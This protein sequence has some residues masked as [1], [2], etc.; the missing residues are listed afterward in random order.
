MRQETTES[1]AVVLVLHGP[2]IFDTGEAA[3]L[4]Q[5][6][7]PSRTIVTGVMARTAAEESGLPVEYDGSPP[8]RIMRALG[9]KSVLANHAKTPESGRIFGNIVASRLGSEG[10]IQIE[11]S[12]KTVIVWDAGDKK[13]ASDISEAT[14]YSLT[15]L[16]ST[17]ELHGNER[18]IRGCLPGEPVYVN[19]MIIGHATQDTVV[20]RRSGTAIEAVSGLVPKDHGIEKLSGIRPLDLATAWCK[21]GQ[22]R[23]VAP[24]YHR[25]QVTSGRVVVVDHCGHEIYGKIGPDCCGVLAIGD[26]TTA[27][28]GHICSHRGIPVLGIVDGDRDTIL[29]SAFADG[30]VVLEAQG[31]RDDDLGREVAR[32]AEPG[33]VIWSDWVASVLAAF[34]SRVRVAVDRRSEDR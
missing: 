2:E 26:D 14:G 13:T 10:L 1:R 28:C 3:W 30:S 16:P 8:T 12:D 4:M 9:G 18:K 6:I 27:V 22:I 7:R 33:P 24:L 17:P 29:M 34:K 25:K 32:M 15:C 31:E 20:I 11:C 23:T 5:V 19:G 21:S